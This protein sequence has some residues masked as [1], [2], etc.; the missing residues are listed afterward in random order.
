MT[1]Y[2]GGGGSINVQGEEQKKLDV[3]TNDVLSKNLK[4][5]G[6]VLPHFRESQ[7]CASAGQ[8]TTPFRIFRWL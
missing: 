7:L 6:Q 5:T 8:L 1:G 2:E 4:F 3:I